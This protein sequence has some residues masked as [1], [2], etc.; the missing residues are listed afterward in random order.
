MKKSNIGV[1][2]SS[3]NVFED[4]GFPDAALELARSQLAIRITEVIEKRGLTQAQAAKLLGIDQPKISAL[5]RG[6]LEGFSAERLFKFLNALEQDIDIV[7]R[8]ARRH[9][10]ATVR[11]REERKSGTHV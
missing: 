2:Q 1:T 10:V 8:P 4:L 3:G 7:V 5:S 6:R 11:V 9:E